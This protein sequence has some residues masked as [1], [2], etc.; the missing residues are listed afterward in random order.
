ML[1]L[2][3]DFFR[4][5]CGE[6]FSN[7]SNSSQ[8][9]WLMEP[10]LYLNE[11]LTGVHI[12]CGGIGIPFNLFV[13]TFIVALERLHT[14]RNLFWIGVGLS[15]L[16]ILIFH[17]L[18]VIA[19]QW[20]SP[21]I[22]VVCA[23]FNG[24]PYL[25]LLL[26][27]FLS[28]L[29]RYLCVRHSIWFKRHI[30]N[31]RIV[32]SQLGSFLFLFLAFKGRHLFG[33][34]PICWQSN[35]TDLNVLSSFVV[36]GFFL[37]FVVHLAVVFT[38]NRNYPPAEID[39]QQRH[40]SSQRVSGNFDPDQSP[41]D[42]E[43][44][45]RGNSSPFVRIGEERVSRADIEGARIVSGSFLILLFLAAPSFFLLVT[46]DGCLQ[47]GLPEELSGYTGLAQNLY[48]FRGLIPVHCSSISPFI[49]V[50]F[51]RDINSALRQR[52]MTLRRKILNYI[53]CHQNN[54]ANVDDNHAEF[55]SIL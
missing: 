23:W 53:Y 36:S 14:S 20:P 30:T 9:N 39:Q 32:V 47:Y 45:L 52:I 16:F 4:M 51:C 5:V 1:R 37:C 38:S 22:R 24:L 43:S 46:L 55:E 28:L 44:N 50:F 33:A 17:L 8:Q 6:T 34:V 3:P 40:I 29:E 13:G 12:I 2:T 21:L 49:V 7:G 41:G 19:A 10:A 15:N 54:R 27:Y 31:G 11:Y 48:Y 42:E 35:P 25:T 26:S 18:E